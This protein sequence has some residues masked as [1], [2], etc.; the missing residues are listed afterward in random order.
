MKELDI[1]LPEELSKLLQAVREQERVKSI[2]NILIREGNT[3]NGITPLTEQECGIYGITQESNL[4]LMLG[5]FRESVKDKS[6]KRVTITGR[7]LIKHVMG[8]AIN[9]PNESSDKQYD[10]TINTTRAKLIEV[11]RGYNA[12]S[13]TNPEG[14]R[15][16]D[17]TIECAEEQADEI[18]RRL[19]L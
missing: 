9:T 7:D 12:D 4:S 1:Q 8:K 14:F 3:R 17:N 15:D 5:M 19:E 10:C 2:T 11:L 16:N 6:S 18:I 13:I